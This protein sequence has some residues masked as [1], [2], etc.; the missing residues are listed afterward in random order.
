MPISVTG[1]SRTEGAP[2][3][4]C[5][6]FSLVELL[7][8]LFVVV[9]ITSLATLNVGSGNQDQLLET[10]MRE[11][12]NVSLFAIDEAQLSG[13]DMGL[14][15]LQDSRGPATR[16]GYSWRERRAEGWRSPLTA[17]DVFETRT[18]PPEV[19]LELAL[20]DAPA[21]GPLVAPVG[22]DATPQVVFHASGE[23]T[24]GQLELRHRD[25]G[26]LLWRLQWD[27]L[28]RMELLQRGEPAQEIRRADW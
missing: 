21:V 16:S 24:P 20:E 7:V 13:T 28:G 8:A 14:L 23:T 4:E 1:K 3:P 11:L 26:E 2:Q 10:H 18:L 6:G 25:S 17:T 12:Q 27:L 19:R 22:D 5:R 9:I 15:L